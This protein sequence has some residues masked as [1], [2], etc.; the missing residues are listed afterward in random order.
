MSGWLIFA[1]VF[2]PWVL[3]SRHVYRYWSRRGLITIKDNECIHGYGQL[4]RTSKCHGRHEAP[5]LALAALAMLAAAFL[6]L[7]LTLLFII[8]NTPQS[9]AATR[10]RIEELERENRELQRKMS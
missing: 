7:T 1:A 5:R 6:P 2:I 10:Q 3:L 8:H 4:H 9:P